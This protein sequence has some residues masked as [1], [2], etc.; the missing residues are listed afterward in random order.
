MLIKKADGT[1]KDFC[2]KKDPF[3]VKL[4]SEAGFVKLDPDG[5]LEESGFHARVFA[6]T[7]PRLNVQCMYGC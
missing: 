7:N 4:S 6:V 1:T 2:G 3:A 5:G